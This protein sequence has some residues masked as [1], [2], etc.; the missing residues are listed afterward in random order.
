MFPPNFGR[1]S[2]ASSKSCGFCERDQYD[3]FISIVTFPLYILYVTGA[4]SRTGWYFVVHSC[5]VWTD[6]RLEKVKGP[7][8]DCA[9]SPDL[10][11]PS[12]A[13]LSTTFIPSLRLAGQSPSRKHTPGLW[14]GDYLLPHQTN[15]FK[16]SFGLYKNS[17]AS[18][19]V[20]ASNYM[21]VRELRPEN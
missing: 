12:N 15:A 21:N 17:D 2:S 19:T 9:V 1:P 10:R 20:M 7:L 5:E 3:Y 16:P 18:A 4:R 6:L 8:R 11:L 13:Q 14:W